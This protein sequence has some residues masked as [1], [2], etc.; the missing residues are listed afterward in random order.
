[1][2]IRYFI[3]IILWKFWHQIIN[4]KLT[5]HALSSAPNHHTM[6]RISSA[7]LD[8]LNPINKKVQALKLTLRYPAQ[9]LL[10]VSVQLSTPGRRCLKISLGEFQ[11]FLYRIVSHLKDRKSACLNFGIILSSGMFALYL[12]LQYRLAIQKHPRRSILIGRNF[13]TFQ[14]ADLLQ[15]PSL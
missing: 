5:F 14:L 2:K 13:R 9:D 12:I 1:M 7:F 10:S 6:K 8:G 3:L 15:M 4:K 11:A